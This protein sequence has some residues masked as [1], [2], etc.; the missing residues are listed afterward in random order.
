MFNDQSSQLLETPASVRKSFFDGL[1]SIHY[2]W[3]DVSAHPRPS[4]HKLCFHIHILLCVPTDIPNML[5]LLLMMI[6]S[7]MH[8]ILSLTLLPPMLLHHHSLIHTHL[9]THID[10]HMVLFHMDRMVLLHHY[11]PRLVLLLHRVFLIYFVL[12]QPRQCPQATTTMPL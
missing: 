5:L 7:L 8:L 3:E 6:L 11:V 2:R 1:S 12:M 9:H 10:I 4:L